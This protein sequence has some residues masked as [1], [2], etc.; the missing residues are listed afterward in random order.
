MRIQYVSDLHLEH[1]RGRVPSVADGVDCVVIAGDTSVPL[2]SSLIEI[3]RAIDR[4]VP[5]VTVAGNHEFYRTEMPAE[6]EQA[7]L[8]AKQ[9]GIHL[10]END[11]VVIEGVR[12]VGASL[13]TD[14]ALFGEAVRPL[15]MREAR[16]RMNDH[17]LIKWQKQP[18]LRFR[19]EEALHLHRQSCAFIERT[20][21]EPFDGASVV[22]T[23]HAPHPD[24]LY[25]NWRSS[26]LSAAYASDLTDLIARLQPEVWIHGHIHRRVDYRIGRTRVLSNPCGYP[27]EA[28]GFDPA[29]SV[30]VGS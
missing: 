5:V 8:L 28:T 23:H 27:G 15:A 1:S 13:W 16:D 3:R 10:L 11:C 24:S 9:L 19:P 22:V 29:L 26:F 7:R 12:F 18:W 17:K 2:Q 14:Y 30:E 21:A 4:S 6:L 20:L 25:E